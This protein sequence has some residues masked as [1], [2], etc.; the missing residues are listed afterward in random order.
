MHPNDKH[1]TLV[2]G[3]KISPRE[4]VSLP[5]KEKAHLLSSR[6]AK[7]Q[8]ELILAD[9]A[10][11]ELVREFAP[12]DLYFLVKEVG[13]QDA[14][15]LI[16]FAAPEQFSFFLDLELWQ[17]WQFSP[18]KAMQWLSYLLEGGEEQVVEFFHQADSELL[19][20]IFM[21]EI[22]VG[23][24]LGVLS[25]DEERLADWEHTFDNLYFF[26]V[27]NKDYA[28]LIGRLLDIM[29]RLA[30]PLYLEV[31]EGVKNETAG[32]AE[33]LAFRFRSARL[34]DQGFPEL[35]DALE[36]YVYVNPASYTPRGGK[37]TMT[38]PS[39][40]YGVVPAP[41]RK[42]DSLLQRLLAKCGT[43]DI[44]L[45][46]NYLVNNVLVADGADF[47]EEKHIEGI[48]QRVGDYLTSA[49]DYLSRG[50]EQKA[51]TLLGG[52]SLKDLFRVGFSLVLELQRK[53]RK[54]TSSEYA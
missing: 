21:K 8:L 44:F 25:S 35:E 46:L 2:R 17:R 53:A 39:L 40:S 26:T 32:E 13:E 15:E 1:L 19:T 29:C 11:K 10:G 31:M 27:R 16:H 50:D 36:L 42:G 52:E 34:A 45:E 37:E 41:F 14:L 9:P 48:F 4:F 51:E 5:L 33:D 28:D 12:L 38:T 47:F 22:T 54:V 6:P 3:G 23:G 43:E 18:Q 49:L 30:H 7:E 24:G 20:V